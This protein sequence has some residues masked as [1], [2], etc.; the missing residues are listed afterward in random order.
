MQNLVIGVMS[1]F[2]IWSTGI[3]TRQPNWQHWVLNNAQ[4]AIVFGNVWRNAYCLDRKYIFGRTVGEN[5]G[6]RSP[7]KC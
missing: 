4:L 2:D 3:D 1:T 7:D 6:H 5:I